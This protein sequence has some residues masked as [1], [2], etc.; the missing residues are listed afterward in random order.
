MKFILISGSNSSGKSVFAEEL[1]S[2]TQGK[3]FYIAT[4]KPLTDDNFSRIEKHKKQREHLNFQ[5]L[6]LP[7]EVASAEIDDNS[8]VLLEDV[9]NLFAN[10]FFEKNGNLNSVF[11]DVEKLNQRCET[12]V[13]VT[14]S[15]LKDE[16]YD[17]E[18]SA[19]IN[20][21]NQLN[22]RLFDLSDLAFSMENG[23]AVCVKGEFYGH[24]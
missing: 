13:A 18:T 4:M 15:G 7:Y 8:I 10:A 11:A 9:S 24:F 12:L 2:K 20:G 14:I 22:R 1:I 6:E 21:L 3:R 16:G 17:E 19:Y 23:K 5:T